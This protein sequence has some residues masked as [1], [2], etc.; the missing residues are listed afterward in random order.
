MFFIKYVAQTAVEPRDLIKLSENDNPK[1]Q[2]RPKRSEGPKKKKKKKKKK[3][4]FLTTFLSDQFC[5]VTD[6]LRVQVEK[7]H[8][9][10]K[11]RR[12]GHQID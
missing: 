9:T 4:T 7:E 1:L 8:V 3:G 5:L 6:P 11:S 10:K 2:N 12:R